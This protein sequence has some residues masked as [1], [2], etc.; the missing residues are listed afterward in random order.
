LESHGPTGEVVR[1]GVLSPGRKREN[2][3]THIGLFDRPTL[4]LG[5]IFQKI[6]N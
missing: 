5:E 2:R 1:W 3:I 4:A 6:Q